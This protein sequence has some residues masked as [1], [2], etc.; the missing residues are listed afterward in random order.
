MRAATDGIGYGALAVA[1]FV[2]GL[3]WLAV[4]CAVDDEESFICVVTFPR[5]VEYRCEVCKMRCILQMPATR[6]YA[7]QF[8]R[9]F[10]L[11]HARCG[12]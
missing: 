4:R 9:S 2:A 7:M 11:L 3:V 12:K 1:L 10:R 6:D 5:H 8:D